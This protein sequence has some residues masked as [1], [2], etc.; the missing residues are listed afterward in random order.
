MK[1]KKP[2][3]EQQ[4]VADMLALP[5]LKRTAIVGYILADKPESKPRSIRRTLGIT[6]RQFR[7]ARRIAAMIT[8]T[9]T[10]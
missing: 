4:A 3:Q 5:R 8:S 2:T 1:H 6:H 10:K 9:E 7:K